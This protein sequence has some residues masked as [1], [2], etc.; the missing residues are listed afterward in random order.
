MKREHIIRI[1]AGVLV[2]SGLAL[3]RWVDS[4]FLLLPLFVGL[5]LLQSGFS[6][7]CLLEDMLER[8][9]IGRPCN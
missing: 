2:I 6:R 4:V 7:W 1:V 3:G 5:N 8:L 9:N